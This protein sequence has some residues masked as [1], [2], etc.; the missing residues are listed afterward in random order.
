MQEH[1]AGRMGNVRNTHIKNIQIVY[2]VTKLVGH[3][4]NPFSIPPPNSQLLSIVLGNRTSRDSEISHSPPPPDI[5]KRPAMSAAVVMG[6]MHLLATSWA[7]LG[8]L[9]FVEFELGGKL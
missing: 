5:S 1:V 9:G 4:V 6:A 2:C 8:A 3:I 7:T